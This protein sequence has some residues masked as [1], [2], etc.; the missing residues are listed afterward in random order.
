MDQVVRLSF[1]ESILEKACQLYQCNLKS[2]KILKDNL[3][4]V[5]ECSSNKNHVVLRFTHSSYKGQESICKELHWLL[6]LHDN[7]VSVAKPIYS[8]RQQLVETIPC[9]DST[10]FTV[11]AFEK[12]DGRE[13]EKRD[14]N[15]KLFHNLGKL[16]GKM[17]Q[18][19]K[20][21]QPEDITW[22]EASWQESENIPNILRY[23]PKEETSLIQ[24]YHHILEHLS[25]LPTDLHSYGMIH[26][27]VHNGNYLLKEKEIVL[28]DFEDCTYFW[29]ICDISNVFFYASDVKFTREMKEKKFTKYFMTA[30]W[31]GYYHENDLN[32]SWHKEIPIFLRLRSMM[33]YA[34]L[35]R[36]WDVDNLNKQQKAYYDLLQNKMQKSW[37]YFLE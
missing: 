19:S 26:N 11:V 35:H 5:Y 4:L 8:T 14:W 29:F 10:Y 13:I 28:F 22:K 24:D 34:Y 7:Q 32:Q 37:E 30:F 16:V 21:Y 15:K 27:D 3:N 2:A 18:L 20:E 25:G 23:L 12:I 9:K 31:D 1:H 17:H 6:Y 36:V 33:V